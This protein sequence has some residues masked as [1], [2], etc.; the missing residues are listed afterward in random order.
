MAIYG[1]FRD[2]ISVFTRNDEIIT[3]DTHVLSDRVSEVITNNSFF[4]LTANHMSDVCDE[5]QLKETW[6]RNLIVHQQ[7]FDFN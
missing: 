5:V 4:L 1:M 7:F 2:I 6:H 3:Q